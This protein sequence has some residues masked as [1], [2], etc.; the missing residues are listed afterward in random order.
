MNDTGSSLLVKL[1]GSYCRDI[2]KRQQRI[3]L[4]KLPLGVRESA[5]VQ[6][7]YLQNFICPSE[8]ATGAS[9]AIVLVG[10]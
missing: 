4:L 10:S 2:P 6:L 7:C 3:E 1:S 8:D 5:S 9:A